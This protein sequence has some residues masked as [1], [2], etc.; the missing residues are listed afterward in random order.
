M[1]KLSY[2]RDVKRGLN[3][4]KLVPTVQKSYLTVRNQRAWILKH[5]ALWFYLLSYTSVRL[6]ENY[7]CTAFEGKVTR[8]IFGTQTNET[9]EGL[10][11][12]QLYNLYSLANIL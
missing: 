7:S 6:H 4:G 5:T 1:F 12:N 10:R 8:I 2:S 11:N 9:K 3:L